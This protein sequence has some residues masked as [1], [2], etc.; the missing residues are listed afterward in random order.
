[1]HTWCLPEDIA[2]FLQVK[3]FYLEIEMIHWDDMRFFLA[4][5][6]K[7]TFVSAG[8]DLKVTHTT[9]ARRIGSLEDSLRSQLFHRTEKGCRLT[10][11]GEKLVQYA[12]RLESTVQNLTETVSG[13]NYELSGAI[14]IGA[15]DGLGN[16]YLAACLTRLQE[17]H[18]ALEVELI[19]VPM[20]YSLS[21]REIDI[22]ITVRKPQVGHAIT[23]KLTEY[24][25]GLFASRKYLESAPPI[26]KRDDLKEHKI[27]GYIDDLLFD[28]DLQ[29]IEEISPGLTTHFRST[30]VIAQMKAVA[31]GAG[32]GVIPYFMAHGESELVPVLSC[33]SIERGYW[34]QVHPDSRQLTRVRTTID[35]LVEQT[36]SDHELF[37]K[38]RVG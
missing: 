12:E 8:R 15:P 7:K 11:A 21:K 24:R 17:L 18:P 29:F 14:R 22:L 6:R 37:V 23:R 36:R 1:M 33:H 3:G 27:I 31:S 9:V 4:L 28:R 32:I 16:W 26:S 13:H 30:T 34:L 19:A 20:Y 5:C 2:S 38:L 25:L 10:P 35:F